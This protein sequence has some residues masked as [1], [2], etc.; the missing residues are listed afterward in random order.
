MI[1]D[2]KFNQ[3]STIDN[4]Q[5]KGNQQSTIDNPIAILPLS[6]FRLSWVET[7]LEVKNGSN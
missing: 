5:S 1:V 3:Q 7:N 4:R 2:W 6:H